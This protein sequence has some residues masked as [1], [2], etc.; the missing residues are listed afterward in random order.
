M[1]ELFAHQKRKGKQVV[2]TQKAAKR[3]KK[4]NSSESDTPT[5]LTSPSTEGN[6][7]SLKKLSSCDSNSSSNRQSIRKL[8]SGE[9]IASARQSIRKQSSKEP[10]S[11][12]SKNSE[13]RQ[14]TRKP[15]GEAAGTGGRERRAT[16]TASGKSRKQ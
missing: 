4:S 10:G 7:T 2:A 11:G 3:T 12:S 5:I 16:K 14:T 15:N 6:S 1:K 13:R 9:E 8:P